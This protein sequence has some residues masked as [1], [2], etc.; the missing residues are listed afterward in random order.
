[1]PQRI[2]LIHAGPVS[3]E[4]VETALRQLWPDVERVNLMD[5][6]LMTDR[7]QSPE[8]TPALFQR[9]VRLADYGRDT[10]ADGIL[11]T[12]SAFGAAIEE[13]ARRAVWPV[14][15]PNEAMFEAAL[16]KGL[17]IG[18]VA[19]FQN[20]LPGMEAEFR[21]LVTAR[22]SKATIRSLAVPEALAALQ[23]GDGAAHDELLAEGAAK[24]GRCD[25]IM[26]AQFS[27]ARAAPALRR[28]VACPVLTAPDT[29]VLKMRRVLG[30]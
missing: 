20:S 29:A 23:R 2:A 13:A 9:I 15:K 5:D 10:G 30:G 21:A 11:F 14:L 7:A 16:E 6:A 28:R 1:M 12:C 17:D 22:G 25:A 18:M 26:L 3:I 8:L 27:T 19:S 24:L 4:P